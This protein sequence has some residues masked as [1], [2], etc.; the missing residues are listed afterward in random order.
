MGK[1]EDCLNGRSYRGKIPKHGQCH[2][3]P[4]TPQKIGNRCEEPLTPTANL[5]MLVSAAFGM[6]N[7]ERE[8]QQKRELFNDEDEEEY[9]E[10]SCSTVSDSIDEKQEDLPDGKKPLLGKDGIGNS[11]KL[12][13][14]GLLCK[15]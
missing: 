14:L 13:S 2:S 3:L 1:A 6:A 12:K 5:K 11:R 4:I 8:G 9:L 15:K 7:T 10:D